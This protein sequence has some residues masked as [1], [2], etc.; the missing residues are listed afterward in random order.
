[1]ASAEKGDFPTDKPRMAWKMKPSARM[2]AGCG[3]WTILRFGGLCPEDKPGSAG[4]ER[5]L[6]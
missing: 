1:M 5:T 2:R 4:V 3:R 6:E